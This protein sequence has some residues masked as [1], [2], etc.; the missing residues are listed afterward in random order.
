MKQEFVCDLCLDRNSN[1]LQVSLVGAVALIVVTLFVRST[2]QSA[3]KKHPIYSVYLKIF[4]NHLQIVAL[5][6]N[7]EF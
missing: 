1:I 7:I 2:M 4:A 3:T 5:I 6:S